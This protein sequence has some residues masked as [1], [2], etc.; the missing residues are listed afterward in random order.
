MFSKEEQ[1]TMFGVTGG[2]PKYLSLF[3]DAKTLDENLTE[4]FFDKDSL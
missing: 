1:A 3:G 2:I 4:Q